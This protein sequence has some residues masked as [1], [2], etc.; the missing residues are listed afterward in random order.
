MSD[1]IETQPRPKESPEEVIRRVGT[2]APEA[3]EFLYRALAATQQL[4][5]RDPRSKDESKRHVTGRELLEGVRVLALQEYG[6]MARI[7]LEGWGIRK[8]DD[9]G[10]MVF[11]LVESG[12]MSKRETD[13][14]DDFHDVYDFREA[15]DR[16]FRFS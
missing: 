11:A 8:T 3:Y 12:H 1:S 4:F 10:R 14:I 7:V 9:F 13:S 2:Y 16:R 15:F 5:Q 6:Y